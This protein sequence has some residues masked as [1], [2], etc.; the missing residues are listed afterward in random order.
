MI[1]KPKQNQ[2]MEEL[3]SFVSQFI[4]VSL[5][6]SIVTQIASSQEALS[7]LQDD[8]LRLKLLVEKFFVHQN[9]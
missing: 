2:S 8:M 6:L 3:T 7:K 4:A 5:E 1:I 9:G